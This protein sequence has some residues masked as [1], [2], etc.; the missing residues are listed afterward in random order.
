[1]DRLSVIKQTF[2]HSVSID[3]SRRQFG[4]PNRVTEAQSD[5]CFTKQDF[6]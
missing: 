2:E 3:R 4:V 1:L 5:T 6:I